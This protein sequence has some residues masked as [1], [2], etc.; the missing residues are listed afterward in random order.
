MMLA[1][2]LASFALGI[3]VTTLLYQLVILNK[4]DQGHCN[5]TCIMADQEYKD[6]LTALDEE[7]RR[8]N[9]T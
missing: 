4:D 1:I 7:E 9:E 3:A 5:K 8:E 6:H 2:G